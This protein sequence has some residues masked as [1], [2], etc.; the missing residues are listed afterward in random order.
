[1][2][3]TVIDLKQSNSNKGIVLPKQENYKIH[4]NTCYKNANPATRTP[5]NST[6]SP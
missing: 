6:T 3:N 4:K 1:M 2:T 5:K